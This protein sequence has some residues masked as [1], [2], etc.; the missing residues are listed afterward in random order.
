MFNARDAF[1]QLTSSDKLDGLL[2]AARQVATKTAAAAPGS[3][4]GVQALD[5][6]A[7][8]LQAAAAR[9][10]EAAA[11]VLAQKHAARQQKVAY[12]THMLHV[13]ERLA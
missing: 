13:L 3:V 10:A 12:A 8:E 4:A 7:A 9:G 6:K 1:N 11:S 5:S 2:A